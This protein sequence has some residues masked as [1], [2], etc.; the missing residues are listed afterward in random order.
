MEMG[1]CLGRDD[2][3]KKRWNRIVL[4]AFCSWNDEL[5]RNP[6]L[7]FRTHWSYRTAATTIVLYFAR[8][9]YSF[10][11]R[12][13]LFHEPRLGSDLSLS[14]LRWRYLRNDSNCTNRWWPRPGRPGPCFV[15]VSHTDYGVSLS[16][17]SCLGVAHDGWITS[18][19]M[20]SRSI[21]QSA[22]RIRWK[23]PLA[24]CPWARGPVT[25][26][27]PSTEDLCTNIFHPVKILLSNRCISGFRD[28]RCTDGF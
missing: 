4:C 5:K 9:S 28:Y 15:Y 20:S 13:R 24:R 27:P 21:I 17:A 2:G 23:D 3:A 19:K 14:I 12:H 7:F 16:V 18:A 8:R 26:W 11:R 22:I 25:Q 10:I 1:K 6:I